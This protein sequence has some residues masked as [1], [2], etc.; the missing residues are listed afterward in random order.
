MSLFID[1]IIDNYLHLQY[2]ISA[3]WEARLSSEHVKSG[4]F[5]QRRS[6]FARFWQH[7][8]RLPSRWEGAFGERGDKKQE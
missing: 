6:A 3:P 5:S 8:C 4:L 7:L 1:N 2:R